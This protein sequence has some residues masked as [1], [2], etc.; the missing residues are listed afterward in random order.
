MIY[1]NEENGYTVL[2]LTDENGELVTV[3]GC[4]PYASVG[5]SMILS[6][7]WTTHSVHGKQFKSEFAQRLLPNSVD[8]IYS[9]LAGGTIKGIGPR[10]LPRSASIW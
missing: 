9:F 1:K 3:V 2:R 4:I 5:E 8:A 10:S 6:G 7:N